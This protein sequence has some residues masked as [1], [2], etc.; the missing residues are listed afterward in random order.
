MIKF[1]NEHFVFISFI[2]YIS[3]MIFLKYKKKYNPDLSM[4]FLNGIAHLQHHH[5]DGFNYKDNKRLIYGLEYVDKILKEI[6]DN[7]EKNDT[8]IMITALSQTNTNTESPWLL[9]RQLD[10]NS[11]LENVNI[12]YEKVEPHM[13]YDAHIFFKTEKDCIQA[14][15]ILQEA[16]IRGKPLFLVE[17]Y[18][19]DGKKLFYR[20]NFS[21]VTI[22][23][24]TFNINGKTFQFF[25][26]FKTI[27]RR[28]G[29]HI[30]EGSI[31]SNN[32]ENIP[33]EIYNH[34]FF[35]YLTSLFEAR[36]SSDF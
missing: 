35:Q 25:D 7:M 3:T 29:K 21:Y 4:I 6:F 1:K 22:D 12:V 9:Y 5:W 23:S 19:D 26:Y 34:E 16:E 36:Y 28:T 33:E 27:I 14:F 31:Y 10:Q 32:A 8:F 18:P 11:F 13:T 24:E 2:D 15:H 17:T 20:I 30:P